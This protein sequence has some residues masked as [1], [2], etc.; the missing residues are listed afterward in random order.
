MVCGGRAGGGR[1]VGKGGEERGGGGEAGY[2]GRWWR[3]HPVDHQKAAWLGDYDTRHQEAS[4]RVLKR[5]VMRS[6]WLPHTDCLIGGTHS[7]LGAK[8]AQRRRLTRSMEGSGMPPAAAAAA[9]AACCCAAIW[10]AVISWSVALQGAAAAGRERLGEA[11]NLGYSADKHAVASAIQQ[12]CQEG[13]AASA[14]APPAGAHALQ[15]HGSAPQ[16]VLLPPAQRLV[17][18]GK[19]GVKVD[20]VGVEAARGEGTLLGRW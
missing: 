8:R 15:Q 3:G 7:H 5:A 14:A 10:W 16:H 4:N 12:A 13:R 1:A 19:P 9:P 11:W 20:V 2:L 6:P 18:L 17:A